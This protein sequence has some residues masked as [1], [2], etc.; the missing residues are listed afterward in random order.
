MLNYQLVLL[1]VLVVLTSL[2]A[3]ATVRIF[4]AEDADDFA[5]WKRAETKQRWSEY[6]SRVS[7]LTALIYRSINK[8]ML[9]QW[10]PHALWGEE[11]ELSAALNSSHLH[12]H[13]HRYPPVHHVLKE[14]NDLLI[15]EAKRS[16]TKR[17]ANLLSPSFK[18]QFWLEIWA[19]HCYSIPLKVVKVTN[20]QKQCG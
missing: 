15:N 2:R 16:E 13:V 3:V 12:H 19:G 20:G 4:E 18:V 14:G 6:I 5:H 7:C 10:I 1:L 17:L 11:D 9:Y 8:E